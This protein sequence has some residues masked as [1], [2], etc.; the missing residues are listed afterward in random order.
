M[1][2]TTTPSGQ[3]AFIGR[4]STLTA[5]ADWARAL[6]HA[7]FGPIK[8]EVHYRKLPAKAVLELWAITEVSEG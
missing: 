3:T 6:C 8:G 4:P 5:I 2:R 1:I 7:V